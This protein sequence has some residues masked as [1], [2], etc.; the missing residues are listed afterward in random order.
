MWR[1]K[2]GYG[3]VDYVA[4]LQLK[5]CGGL[6]RRATRNDIRAAVSIVFIDLLGE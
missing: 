6:Y 3:Y 4:I 5:E 1:P 2:D